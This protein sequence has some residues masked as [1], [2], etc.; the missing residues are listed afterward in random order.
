MKRNRSL[1]H[2]RW[3]QLRMKKR[4]RFLSRLSHLNYLR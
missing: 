2:V 3:H 4:P 1:D